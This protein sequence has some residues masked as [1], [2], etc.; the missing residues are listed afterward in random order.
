MNSELTYQEPEP[1]R[2]YREYEF[3]LGQN[4]EWNFGRDL[5][6][7]QLAANAGVTWPNFWESELSGTYDFR[8][9]DMRL[10]R[11]G[12]SME[13][14][15]AWG[16]ALETETSDATQTQ[17]RFEVAYGGT[18]DRGLNFEASTS[19]TLRPA[20]QWQ[21]S[22]GPSYSR[23][24]ETQ[25]YVTTRAGGGTATYGG[26]YIFGTIDRSTYAAEIRF[27]Y[28]FKPDLTL[29]FYGEPFA[30]SGRY[31]R[32]GELAAARGRLLLP[33]DPALLGLDEDFKVR[34]FRSNVVLRWEWRAG[35]TIYLVWQQ[36]RESELA[37]RNRAGAGDLFRSFGAEGDNIFA[38]KA[39]FWWA[40]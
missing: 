11:G 7:A 6:S 29:D 8:R 4:H 20:P 25:Q 5:Q 31:T 39:S 17:G 12:P 10:T 1:G 28:T 19:I 13:R 23:E 37:Q 21:V 24:V 15:A 32:F 27:N 34:S 38:V 3:T 16:L 35:S 26:R 2:W 9:Q 22:I 40:P 36:D 18:E 30:A 33:V 14:P